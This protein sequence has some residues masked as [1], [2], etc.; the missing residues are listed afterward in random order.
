LLVSAVLTCVL[1]GINGLIVMNVMHAVLPT[2]PEEWRQQPRLAQAIVFL[3]PLA[4]LFIEWWICDVTLDWLRPV[5][6]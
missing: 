3:G 6:R 1:L 4:L 5:R 2:L